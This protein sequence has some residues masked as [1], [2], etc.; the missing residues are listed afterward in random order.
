[1]KIYLFFFTDNRYPCYNELSF[2]DKEEN[3]KMELTVR[4]I[5]INNQKIHTVG[6]ISRVKAD[7]LSLDCIHKYL[8]LYGKCKIEIKKI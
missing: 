4:E 8:A 1:V 2:K 6:S 3:K 7:K 5:W